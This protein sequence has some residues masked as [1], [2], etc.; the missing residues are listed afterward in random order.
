MTDE[1]GTGLLVFGT[2]PSFTT[3]ATFAA[4]AELRLAD[5]DSSNY[6]GFVSPAT[7]TANQI[8]TLPAADGSSGQVLSTNGAGTLAWTSGGG[9]GSAVI[10]ENAQ[11][12]T[13][14]YTLSTG[15]NGQ[16]VGPVTISTGVSVTVGTEQVWVIWGV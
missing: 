7:V 5:S 12:I 10:L 15:Y 4:Q 13:T 2:N 16:S 9:G 14:N 8:W 6:V 1:T 3:A 11:T